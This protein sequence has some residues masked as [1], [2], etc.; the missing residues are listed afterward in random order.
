MQCIF[1]ITGNKGDAVLVIYFCCFPECVFKLYY[2]FEKY[3]LEV[4]VIIL[5]FLGFS[6]FHL[7]LRII[8]L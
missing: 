1:W 5:F 7:P 6:A 4:Q 3:G 8:I 2:I